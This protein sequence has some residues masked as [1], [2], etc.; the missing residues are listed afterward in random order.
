MG[1]RG[2]NFGCKGVGVT[3]VVAEAVW[4]NQH[5]FTR[6]LHHLPKHAGICRVVLRIP[7]RWIGLCEPL[8]RTWVIFGGIIAKEVVYNCWVQEEC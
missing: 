8:W 3:K 5:S 1:F 6:W 2:G 7:A 4:S